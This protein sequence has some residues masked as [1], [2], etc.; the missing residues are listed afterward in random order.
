MNVSDL[1]NAISVVGFPVIMCCA[2]FWYIYTSQAKTQEVLLELTQ[3]I[4]ELKGVIQNVE[5]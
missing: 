2:L 3:A 4:S 5:K 1:L